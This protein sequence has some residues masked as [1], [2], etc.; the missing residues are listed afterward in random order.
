M[1]AGAPRFDLPTPECLGDAHAKEAGCG[2]LGDQVEREPPSVLDLIP[3][4]LD[5]RV[6]RT[7]HLT[8]VART[9][10]LAHRKGFF[11]HAVLQKKLFFVREQV[12]LFKAANNYDI[13]DPSTNAIVME[14]REPNLGFLT[15]LL[16]F[17][18]DRLAHGGAARA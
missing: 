18:Q 6:G 8:S 10:T 14:C 12:A 3:S 1:A 17:T 5:H 15:K 7:P 16:R 11:M 4:T 13:H 2:E 9:A